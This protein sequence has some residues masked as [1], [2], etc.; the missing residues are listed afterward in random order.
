MDIDC[1]TTSNCQRQASE[2]EQHCEAN[3]ESW[4]NKIQGTIEGK[5]EKIAEKF[6]VTAKLEYAHNWGGSQQFRTCT[7]GTQA[8]RCTWDDKECHSFW[9]ARRNHRIHGYARRTCNTG[10]DG[11]WLFPYPEVCV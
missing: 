5:V 1:A 9:T 11:T 3:T 2:V 7:A 6:G 8:A 10:R 4:D